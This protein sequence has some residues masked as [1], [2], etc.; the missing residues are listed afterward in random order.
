VTGEPA[1]DPAV[2]V[3][4]AVLGSERDAAQLLEEL[5]ARVGADPLNHA[6][7]RL[8]YRDTTRFQAERSGATT[9]PAPPP[10]AQAARGGC[11][12][13]KSEFFD[14][15][16]PVRRSRRWSMAWPAG[17]RLARTAV[18]SSRLGVGPTAGGRRGPPRLPIAS[19]C[20]CLST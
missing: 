13:T 6:C 5:V 11:R 14:R 20:L 4:G 7:R 9:Q 19:S 12:F 18:W 3:Y 2:E 16:L 1:A 15:P 10:Q 8:S 17:A